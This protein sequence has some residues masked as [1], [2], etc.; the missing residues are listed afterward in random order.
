MIEWLKGKKTYLI[1]ASAILT[2]VIAYLSDSITIGELVTAIY[3]AIT[4]MSLRGGISKVN[5]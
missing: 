3:A 4:G 1:C 5:E 2:A